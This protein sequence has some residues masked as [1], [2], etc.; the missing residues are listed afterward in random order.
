VPLGLI[1]ENRQLSTNI[2]SLRERE[3]ER[4]R[5][6]NMKREEDLIL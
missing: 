2:K 5:E 3:R 1:P 6:R 4:E